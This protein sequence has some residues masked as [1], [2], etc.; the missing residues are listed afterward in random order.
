LDNQNCDRQGEETIMSQTLVPPIDPNEEIHFMNIDETD[1]ASMTRAE[2]IRHLE[3]EGYVVLPKILKPTAIARI[4]SE[5]A[6][7]KMSP[8]S[9]SDYQT[10]S[11]T[12]PQWLSTAVA[13]LIGYPPLIEFLTD[14]MGPDIVFT[15]GFFQRTLPG[16]P[17]ISMHTDGQPHGSN[18]FGYEGSCPRLLRVLYY[19]DELT[20]KRAPFRLIPRSHLSFHGEAS[21]YV[22]YKSHPEEITLI[23]PAGSA[24]VVPSMLLHG[25]H[26]NKDPRPRELVQLGYRPAWA[27]PIQPVDEWDSELVAAAPE[28]AKPF[29]KSLNTTGQNWEQ[30]HKPEGMRSEAPGINPSRWGD[31]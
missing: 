4:K 13:E 21:P 11:D 12:Q 5:L 15:R 1:F 31:R 29:L 17:G 30:Q 22:R 24:V 23:V 28:I 25:S 9:Y 2:Q 16:S 26:P 19:L 3:V 10:R 20:P 27:G 7:A 18:L 14:L 6:D 8:T